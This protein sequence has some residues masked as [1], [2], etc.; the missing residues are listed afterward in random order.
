MRPEDD[1]R[2]NGRR[3]AREIREH[4]QN[5]VLELPAGIGARLDRPHGDV[6][7]CE[8]DDVEA[9]EARG[10]LIL[11]PA[12][13]ARLPLEAYRE[14][15]ELLRR[16]HRPASKVGRSRGKSTHE[17]GRCAESRSGG[18]HVGDDDH[19]DSFEEA[20]VLERGPNIWMR[21]AARDR[22]RLDHRVMHPHVRVEHVLDRDVDEDVD[23]RGDH[24]T[25][26]AREILR[27]V[28]AAADEAEP[29]RRP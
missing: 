17:R 19:F 2:L 24:R 15:G 4:E 16:S 7:A 10:V 12:D 11:T 20:E 18:H 13:R 14:V 3:I 21:D 29:Q 5:T 28:G 26:P 9:A 27:K 6:V 23:R 1:L 8:I 25:R 22:L